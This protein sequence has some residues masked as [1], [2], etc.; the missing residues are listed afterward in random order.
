M[1]E[2][3]ILILIILIFIS[4]GVAFYWYEWRP[5]QIRK[6]CGQSD[7]AV[8]PAFYQKCLHEKGIEK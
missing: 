5:A 4:L 6:E 7:D 8:I 2:K 1:K 3:I